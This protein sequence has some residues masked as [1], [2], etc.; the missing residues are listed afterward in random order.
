MTAYDKKELR[1]CRHIR[2]HYHVH[3]C[4]TNCRC[5]F[6]N[7]HHLCLQTKSKSGVSFCSAKVN[8][9][10]I[11]LSTADKVNWTKTELFR[12][13]FA[14]RIAEFK[15]WTQRIAQQTFSLSDSLSS[16]PKRHFT[17]WIKFGLSPKF[18][19]S[20]RLSERLTQK[21][22]SPNINTAKHE[23][24]IVRRRCTDSAIAHI[25]EFAIDFTWYT[26]R[27]FSWFHDN[28]RLAVAMRIIHR[29]IRRRTSS[30]LL[31]AT[32]MYFRWTQYSAK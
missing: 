9:Y 19:L 30:N 31:A 1:H 26:S 10:G 5:G 20:K 4:I 12:L 6:L 29:L 3:V 25:K 15:L 8:P 2:V 17:F 14:E 16:N 13:T 7:Y 23:N 22:K 18:G 32:S 24:I 27:S 11:K 21:V 28:C